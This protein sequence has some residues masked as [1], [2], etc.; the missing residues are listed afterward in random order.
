MSKTIEQIR[1]ELDAKIPRDAIASRPGGSG[2][3][4]SYL[5]GWYVIARMNEVFGQGNWSYSTDEVRLVF[6][7]EVNDKH[8]A[9]YITQVS[10][11]VNIGDKRAHF[12][13]CGYGDGSDGYN[14]GKAHE[15]A[16]K[17]SITDG[18]KR[19]AKNLGMS[20]GLALYDKTQENVSDD[21]E[22]S[23][24]GTKDN[25]R[26]VA[27]GAR[28]AQ[29]AKVSPKRGQSAPVETKSEASSTGSEAPKSRDELNEMITAMANVANQK[30]KKTFL[31]IR[32]MMK[33]K[34][35]AD[36]KKKLTDQQATEFYETLQGLIYG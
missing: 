15:L 24:S 6:Q 36:D 26:A 18:L 33:E 9:H 16:V 32:E 30:G 22:E 20:M 27:Q 19:C 4:L 12:S 10:L 11:T 1:E 17:E 3:K 5:E 7:G 34:Y 14:P 2:K 23:G 13:D 21:K 8:V 28:N 31:E 29:P 25:V 35:G